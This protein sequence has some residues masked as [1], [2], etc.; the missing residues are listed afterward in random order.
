MPHFCLSPSQPCSSHA[1][2]Q[3]RTVYQLNETLPE[4]PATTIKEQYAPYYLG[5]NGTIVLAGGTSFK[6]KYAAYAG[7][8]RNALMMWADFVNGDRGGVLLDGARRK[9]ELA[10]V[11][12]NSDTSLAASVMGH[13]L[14][15]DSVRFPRADFALGGYSTS[16]GRHAFLQATVDGRLLVSSGA[17]T[18]SLYA[19]TGLHGFEGGLNFGFLP[20]SKQY[21]IAS[22]EIVLQAARNIDTGRVVAP[23]AVASRCRVGSCRNSIVIGWVQPADS[24]STSIGQHLQA[25]KDDGSIE[26]NLTVVGAIYDGSYSNATGIQWAV[27]SIWE[28]GATLLQPGQGYRHSYGGARGDAGHGVVAACNLCLG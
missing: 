8:I 22:T 17:S 12:D 19:D 23:A 14:R 16:M 3:R 5:D 9:V 11:G 26:R 28:R 24:T 6:G 13:A 7:V 4:L 18:S 21:W 10:F 27:R 1:I 15:G 25:L 20:A 2:R